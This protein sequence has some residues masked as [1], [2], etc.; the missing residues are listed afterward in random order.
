[1]VQGSASDSAVPSLRVLVVNDDRH[2]LWFWLTTLAHEGH[3]V[4]GAF[5]AAEA[6]KILRTFPADLIVADVLRG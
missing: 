4:R 6:S 5:N 1:M 2:S 3:E